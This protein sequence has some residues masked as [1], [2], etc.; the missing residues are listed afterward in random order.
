MMSMR[1]SSAVS[2]LLLLLFP[3]ATGAAPGAGKDNVPAAAAQP[4]DALWKF[5]TDG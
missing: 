4:G 1:P 5:D 2:L 3:S